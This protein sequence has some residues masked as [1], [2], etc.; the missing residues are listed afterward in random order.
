[1]KLKYGKN[2]RLCYM[3]TDSLVYDIKTEGFY[4]DIAGN[5]KARFDMSGC[6]KDHPLLIGVNKKVI[7]LMKDGLGRRIM[8]EFV[9]IR[10]KLYTDKMLSGSGDKRCNRVKKCV[11][12][13]ILDFKDYKQYFSRSEF[14]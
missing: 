1:M 11:M 7:G 13:K 12:K 4:E 9:A 2:L 14:I 10:P 8:T 5:V 3:D 6:S